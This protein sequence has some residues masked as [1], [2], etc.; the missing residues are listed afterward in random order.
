ML[1]KT[2]KH[3][4]LKHKHRNMLIIVKKGTYNNELY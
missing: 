1:L 4:I 3:K 2:E